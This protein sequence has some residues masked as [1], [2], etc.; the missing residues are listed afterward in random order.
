MATYLHSHMAHGTKI[1]WFDIDGVVYGLNSR[2]GITDKYGA[3]I[4][5]VPADVAVAILTMKAKLAN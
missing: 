1:D 5:M 4:A 2:R 3:E